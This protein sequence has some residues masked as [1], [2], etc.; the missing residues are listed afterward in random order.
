MTVFLESE[1]LGN[2]R[3]C[4]RLFGRYMISGHLPGIVHFRLVVMIDGRKDVSLASILGIIQ[5]F[6]GM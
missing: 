2:Y 4:V 6:A 1:I 3:N 5:D